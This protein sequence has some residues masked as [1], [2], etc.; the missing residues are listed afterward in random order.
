MEN[1]KNLESVKT[2]AETNFKVCLTKNIFH[3]KEFL[4][5]FCRSLQ[6]VCK[7]KN[8]LTDFPYFP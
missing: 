2:T 3:D 4:H 6:F 7:L 8:Q 5:M 1:V